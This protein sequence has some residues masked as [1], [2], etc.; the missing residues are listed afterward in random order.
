MSTLRPMFL[1]VILSGLILFTF[2]SYWLAFSLAVGV[3]LAA[4]IA[5]D[6]AR[7]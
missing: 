1:L 3:A 7:L 5:A 2:P 6:I 4:I